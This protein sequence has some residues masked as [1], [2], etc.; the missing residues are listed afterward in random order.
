M[1]L[2]IND[3]KSKKQYADKSFTVI[4]LLGGTAIL[5]I[6]AVIAY[7]ITNRSTDAFRTAGLKFFTGQ[8]FVPN[9]TP[10]VLGILRYIFGTALTSLIAIVLAVPI[11]L[12]LALYTTQVAPPWLKRPLVA[13]TDLVAVV[14][15]VVFGLWGVIYLAPK[16]TTLYKHISDLFDGVPVLGSVFGKVGSG[17]SFMTAGLILAVMITPIITSIARE[18]IETCPQTDRDGA[19]A[20][21]ATRWEMITG[22]VMPHSMGGIVGAVMLGLGRAMGETIAV[23]LVIGSSATITSNVFS[24]G[25]SLPAVIALQWG[26]ANATAKSALIAMGLTLFVMTLVV[27]FAATAVVNRSTK[28]MQGAS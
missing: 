20:L 21:G 7:T 14:P 26:E 28:R 25:D 22:A 27:N 18:V 12:G 15:S 6:L 23:A 1:T 24:S 9:G 4:V 5:L 2:T 8:K 13:L 16:I 10:P 19:L 11:S 17:R 3:L